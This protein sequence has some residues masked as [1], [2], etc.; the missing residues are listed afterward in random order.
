MK[1]PHLD[2]ATH[3]IRFGEVVVTVD[4]ELGDAVVRAPRPGTF[5]Q[6]TDRR[7]FNSLDEI[8]G[9]YAVQISRPA[10]DP[11]AADIARALKFAGQQIRSAQGG[12]RRA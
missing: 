10:T 9:A 5:G 6:G 2:P 8:R 7:R 11:L 12:N 1:S 4:L 3:G